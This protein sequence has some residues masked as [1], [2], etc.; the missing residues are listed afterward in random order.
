MAH[1]LAHQWWGDTITERTWSHVWLSESFATYSE[2]LFS[3]YDRGENEGAVNLLDK[4]NSYLREAREDYIRPVVFNRYETPWDIMD[5]HSYPKGAVILHMLRFVMGDKPFFRT[6]KHFLH[7]HAFQAVD[8]HDF[9]IAV[10]EATGQ[11]LDWFFEQWIFKPGHPVFEVRSDWDAA[12]QKLR[13][14]IRQIQDTSQGIPVYRLP[15]LI[16]ITTRDEDVIHKVWLEQ[17][18]HA[19]EFDVRQ[20]P[21]LVRFD[22]GD[23]LLKEWTF[24]KSTEDLIFQLQPDHDDVIG[25]MWAARE[26]IRFRDDSR[27]ISALKKSARSDPFR[28]VRRQAVETLGR[29]EDPGLRQFLQGC[30]LDT[31]SK[32]R[33]QALDALGKYQ[34]PDSADFF[35]QRFEL[36]DS[37]SAQAQA[38]RSLGEC[39]G[40]RHLP[41]LKEAASLRSPRRIIQRAAE[42]AIEKIKSRK[43]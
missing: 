9:M 29:L 27:V 36:D 38:L 32:V 24:Q 43:K 10:K 22:K 26:L 23:F 18:E 17:K 6:L 3:R 28:H 35:I 34:D 4:K 11:N 21:L 20:R 14:H 37:Y 41:W 13:L 12:A 16:G 7:K 15:V 31:D 5:G 8:T 19:F 30:C 25:R 40:V 42:A 39:G 33:S 1:E 2:Y